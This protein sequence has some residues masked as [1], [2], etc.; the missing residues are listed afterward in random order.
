YHHDDETRKGI[1]AAA[2][3]PDDGSVA[4]SAVEL[5]AIEDWAAFHAEM[6]K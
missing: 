6:L 3:Y 1:L 4:G 5:N 2:G